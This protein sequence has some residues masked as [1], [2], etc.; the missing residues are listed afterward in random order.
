MTWPGALKSSTVPLTVGGS[1]VDTSYQLSNTIL[2]ELAIWDVVKD[3][4]EAAALS[5]AQDLSGNPGLQSW[6]RYEGDPNDSGPAGN[7]GTIH[8]GVVYTADVP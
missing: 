2:D 4:T 1:G 8:G 5:P 7:D 6:W 3:S